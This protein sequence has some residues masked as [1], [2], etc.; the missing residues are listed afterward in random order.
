MKPTVTIVRTIFDSANQCHLKALAEGLLHNEQ[1]PAAALATAFEL[2]VKAND[3][4]MT[5]YTDEHRADHLNILARG[6]FMKGDKEK[7]IEL[8]EKVVALMAGPKV[9]KADKAGRWFPT[10]DR[11]SRWSYLSLLN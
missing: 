11:I 3:G 1:L 9:D 2:A 10:L 5:K 8:Q 6:T 4:D 7:A